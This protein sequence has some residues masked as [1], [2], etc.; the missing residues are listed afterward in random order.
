LDAAALKAVGRAR[1]LPARE[2][3][4]PVAAAESFEIIFRLR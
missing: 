1:F 3:G 2:A 4:R